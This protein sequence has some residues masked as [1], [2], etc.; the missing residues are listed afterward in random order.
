MK[1]AF[2]SSDCDGAG[3]AD[4]ATGVRGVSAGGFNWGP[5]GPQP[6]VVGSARSCR[7]E[8]V[9]VLAMSSLVSAA[10]SGRR[11][12]EDVRPGGVPSVAAPAYGS[13]VARAR[14]RLRPRAEAAGEGP[15]RQSGQGRGRWPAAEARA[16]V[17][18]AL[19]GR[20]R[21]DEEPTGR[22]PCGSAETCSGR[23]ARRD[24][25]ATIGSPKGSG[26]S[27]RGVVQDEIGR[28]WPR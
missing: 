16:F 23:T 24:A 4:D 11:S 8:V 14:A 19:G 27:S 26:P 18:I 6:P 7:V 22:D 9:S 20:A 2:R 12:A 1:G 17:R 13:G 25:K 3:G 10:P 28:G 21:R 15:R 5:T